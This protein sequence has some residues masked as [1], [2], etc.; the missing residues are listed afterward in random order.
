ME[1]SFEWL[2]LS[3]AKRIG[4]AQLAS[5]ANL[6]LSIRVYARG[7]AARSIQSQANPLH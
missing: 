7:T 6:L 5:T 1:I 4:S 2:Q 3:A